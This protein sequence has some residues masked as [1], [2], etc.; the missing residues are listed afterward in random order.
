LFYILQERKQQL[1]S[2]SYPAGEETAINIFFCILQK[3]KQQLI[4][5]PDPAGDET[6]INICS[7]SCRRGNSN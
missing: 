2:V 7:I 4:Y 1:V 6:A 3:R 5:V